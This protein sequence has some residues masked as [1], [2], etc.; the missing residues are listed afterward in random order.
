LPVVS[1]TAQRREL[2]ED[3]VTINTIEEPMS[4][5]ITKTAD[6]V[7]AV[8]PN[9]FGLIMDSGGYTETH[10]VKVK[11]YDVAGNVIESTTT[12][13]LVSHKPKPP[14][15]EAE[16]TGLLISPDRLLQVILNSHWKTRIK[17]IQL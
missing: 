14:T 2:A 12:R 17:K 16:P 5:N 1:Y 8:F 13:F 9:G 15:E 7:V 4:A 3:G 11:A 6:R 10:Q